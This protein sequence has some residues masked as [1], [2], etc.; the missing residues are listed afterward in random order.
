MG[1][2]RPVGLPVPGSVA[3]LGQGSAAAVA[4]LPGPVGLPGL[5]RPVS[6]QFLPRLAS[7][8]APLALTELALAASIRALAQPAPTARLRPV[9]TARTQ[10]VRVLR[11]LTLHV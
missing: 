7:L 2:A 3:R 9:H 8:P 6:A 11:P 10:P 5:A 4:E 1:P